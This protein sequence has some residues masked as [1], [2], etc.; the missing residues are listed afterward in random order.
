MKYFIAFFVI[1]FS[2]SLGWAQGIQGKWKTIDDNTGMPDG[3]VEIYKRNETVYGRVLKT[4]P[5][6]G[7]DPDPTCKECSGKNK[8]QP[9][10][11]M[12]I[13]KEMEL[14]GDTWQDGT[15]L[16]P[17]DGKLYAGKLWLEDGYLKVRGY[18]AFFFRTQTWIRVE[19]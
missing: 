6:P 8:N 10:I 5:G 17:E 9:I 13:I 18:I 12:E 16:D 11:G 4:F 14:S 7:E 15:I 19:D 2:C 3:I 1:L